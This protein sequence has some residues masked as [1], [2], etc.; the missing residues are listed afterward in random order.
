MIFQTLAN[1]TGNAR[2]IQAALSKFFDQIALM[3]SVI[4]NGTWNDSSFQTAATGLCSSL[5]NCTCRLDHLLWI[6]L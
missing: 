5:E 3:P 2:T 1:A 6:L 4:L